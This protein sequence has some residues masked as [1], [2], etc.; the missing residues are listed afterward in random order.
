MGTWLVNNRVLLPHQALHGHELAHREMPNEMGG[1]VR[2]LK[3]RA[4][5][6][7]ET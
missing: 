1:H 3:P 7:S 5:G 4:R 2:V 6:P